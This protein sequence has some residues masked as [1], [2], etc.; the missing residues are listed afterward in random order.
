MREPEPVSRPWGRFLRF[1]VRG[2][3]VLVLVIGGWFGWIVRSA[4]LQREAVAAIT[5]AGGTVTYNWEWRN[6]KS[7]PGGKPWAPKRL[8]DLLGVDYFGHVRMARMARTGVVIQGWCWLV[9]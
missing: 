9:W 5:K 6:G 4:R 7:T 1:S 2:L 3:I 8:V